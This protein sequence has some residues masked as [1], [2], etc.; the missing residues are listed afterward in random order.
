MGFANIV[1]TPDQAEVRYIDR[2]G[3]ELH[4]FT[5]TRDGVVTV[6]NTNG[7]DTPTSQPL[8]AIE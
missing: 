8:R 2:D 5:K 3:N 7:M 4:H 6:L 1:F